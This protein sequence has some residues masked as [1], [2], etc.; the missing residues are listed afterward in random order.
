MLVGKVRGETPGVGLWVDL[1]VAVAS[2]DARKNLSDLRCATLIK[3]G[4]MEAAMV[5]GAEKPRD[6]GFSPTRWATT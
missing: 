3:W 6:Y 2:D 5:Y 1:E 4:L